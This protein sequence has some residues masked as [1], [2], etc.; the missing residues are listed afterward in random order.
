MPVVLYEEVVEEVE[1]WIEFEGRES[2][3]GRLVPRSYVMTISGG[4]RENCFFGRRQTSSHVHPG[5]YS[6]MSIRANLFSLIVRRLARGE[7]GLRGGPGGFSLPNGL[8]N[9]TVLYR[10]NC[11]QEHYFALNDLLDL[12]D[13]VD[14]TATFED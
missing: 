9:G 3:Y 11:Q 6:S 12:A 1:S 2:R 13:I 10:T 8:E 7:T 4:S 14:G 5:A